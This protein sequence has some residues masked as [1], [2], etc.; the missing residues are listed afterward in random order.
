MSL[1]NAHIQPSLETELQRRA[2]SGDDTDATDFWLKYQ[3][4]KNYL[5]KEY[6]PNVL[7]ACP[8]YTDHSDQHVNSVIRTAS[9]LLGRQL[10]D[11]AARKELSNLDLFLILSGI[12]WHDVGMVHGRTGHA[13]RVPDYT[14]EVKR[15]AFPSVPIHRLVDQI[16]QAHGGKYGLDRLPKGR[17]DCSTAQSTYSVDVRALAAIVRFADEISEDHNR[18]SATLKESVPSEN[19]I[20]WEYA[21]A[22][23]ASKPDPLRRHV[24]I[25]YGL[26]KN[27]PSRRFK[28]IEYPDRTDESGELS[29]IEYVICRLEKVNE[30]RAYCAPE[31]RL[32]VLIDEVVARLY[33]YENTQ[34]VPGYQDEIRLGGS[35]LH[36]NDLGRPHI[37][38]FDKFF[39]TYPNWKVVTP[40]SEAADGD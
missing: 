12:I 2:D 40:A 31:F 25:T 14:N 22:I 37:P 33:L 15:L 20:F 30:E 34:A 19:R 32:F 35:G 11:E 26:Q 3:N 9:Q 7:S 1:V 18:V 27:L 29:L 13:Q 39:E 21:H 5:E 17:S 4:V 16:A 24:V 28:C 6:Y 23:E 36:G 38:I 8:Y 10:T